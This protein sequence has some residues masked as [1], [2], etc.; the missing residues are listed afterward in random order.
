[1]STIFIALQCFQC[2]T[3]QVKQQKKSSNKWTCAV[4]NQ[5]QSVRKVF[6]QGFMARDVRKFVQSFNMS[7]QFLEQQCVAE[8]DTLDPL[9]DDANNLSPS[10]YKKRRTDWSEYVDSE[11]NHHDQVENEPEDGFGSKIVTEL[12]KAL[13]RKPKLSTYSRGFGAETSQRNF[14]GVFHERNLNKPPV[15]QDRELRNDEPTTNDWA[16]KWKGNNEQFEEDTSIDK[17]PRTAWATM[18]KV[19]SKGRTYAAQRQKY[20]FEEPSSCHTTAA[21]GSSK[22]SYYNIED[23]KNEDCANRLPLK[24]PERVKGASKWHEYITEDDVERVLEPSVKKEFA[25]HLSQWDD[26]ALKLSVC[27]E[28]VE[29]DIHPDFQ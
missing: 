21:K 27:D 4:C 10:S 16:F 25:D 1:M 29:E 8:A 7:R 28:R 22:W 6:A 11:N 19:A 12:P 5:K 9:P 2:S 3:M 13:L 14:R 24:Q 17:E 18:I 20:D 23:D 26:G 15:S